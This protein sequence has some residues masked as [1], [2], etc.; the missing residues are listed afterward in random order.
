MSLDSLPLNA[1]S[2]SPRGVFHGICDTCAEVVRLLV[3]LRCRTMYPLP[4]WVSKGIEKNG[5]LNVVLIFS[6]IVNGLP[7]A[8]MRT[9]ND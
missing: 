5:H 9:A 2:Y 7:Y 6:K 3:Q 1:L 4:K 8:G